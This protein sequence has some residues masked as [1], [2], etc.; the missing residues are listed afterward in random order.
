M[1]K[2]CV[3]ALA[4]VLIV[5]PFAL[6]HCG[7]DKSTGSGGGGGHIITGDTVGYTANHAATTDFSIIPANTIRQARAQFNIFYG[8]TSHGSQIVTGLGM[9]HDADTLYGYGSAGN[10][11]ITEYSDDLGTGG[12]VSWVPITRA[13]L[14]APGSTY[15][16]VIWS[17]CGGVSSNDE[18]GIQTYLDSMTALEQ[19]YP[20]VTFIYMTGHLDGTGPT[21]NLYVRNNQIRAY[22]E[23]YNKVLFDFADIES[24]S[25]DGTYYPNGS[26]ACEWA[27]DWCASHDCPSCGSC[28]H[29]HCFNCYRKGQAFWWLLARL[30]GWDGK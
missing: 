18:A 14:D 13:Q 26:D 5:L 2:L 15:N 9:L 25:P 24:Y 29:T 28:A 4:L 19:D 16:M 27:T 3:P 11:P 23:S 10:L 12:D 21:G 8:H 17:W 6:M 7:S 20:N 30:S 1:K 22:C